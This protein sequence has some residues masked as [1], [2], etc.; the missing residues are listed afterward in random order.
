MDTLLH[1][2]VD[3]KILID[4]VQEIMDRRL[5]GEMVHFRVII[6]GRMVILHMFLVLVAV[7]EFIMDPVVTVQL[8]VVD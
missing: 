4:L 8:V 5:F 1:V 2:V 7:L 3:H 6:Y